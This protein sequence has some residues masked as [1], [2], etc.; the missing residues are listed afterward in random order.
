MA[1]RSIGGVDHLLVGMVVVAAV[2]LHL[3][4]MAGGQVRLAAGMAGVVALMAGMGGTVALPL[5]EMT[6]VGEEG[7][8]PHEVPGTP[9]SL[10]GQT[11]QQGQIELLLRQVHNEV[12]TV[13]TVHLD[14]VLNSSFATV[15]LMLSI[16][17]H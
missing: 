8:H 9:Q 13:M 6:V 11:L 3:A 4:E 17:F 2:A 15:D 5:V 12:L 16:H 7:A 14:H 10:E 1:V